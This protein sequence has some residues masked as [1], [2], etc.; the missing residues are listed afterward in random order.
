MTKNL[1]KMAV[2]AAAILGLGATSVKSAEAASVNLTFFQDGVDTAVGVGSFSYDES[3][4]YEAIFLPSSRFGGPVEIEASDKLFVVQNLA[5]N[6]LGVSWG[7]SDVAADRS[8]F[9]LSP[10]LWA[11]CDEGQLKVVVGNAGPPI[12]SGAPTLWNSWVFGNLRSPTP[13]SPFMEISGNSGGPGSRMGW[14]QDSFLNG[15]FGP[16]SG[17]V[18]AEEEVRPCCENPEP[19]PEPATTA[20]LALAAAGLG[21]AKKKFGAS[22]V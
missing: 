19:V 22:K 11:P 10:L 15:S 6:L 9:N 7:S 13:S 2:A 5:I 1:Q 16:R 4:P 20:A 17:Y 14:R 8:R 12:A 18:I 3:T 21:Y